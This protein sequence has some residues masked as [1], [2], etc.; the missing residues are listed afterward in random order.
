MKKIYSMFILFAFV[1]FGA[2]TAQAEDLTLTVADG[3]S[4]K[5]QLPMHGYYG[6]QAQHNQFIFLSS[7]LSSMSGATITALKFYMDKNYT[8]KNNDAPTATFRFKEVTETTVASQITVDETFQQVFS[9]TI[10]FANNEWNITLDEPYSYNGG[11]LLIDVQTTAAQYINNN[12]NKGS[13]FYSANVTYGRGNYRGTALEYIPK[14]TFTYEEAAAAGGCNKP[15]SLAIS[16]ELPDGA[17]F[18]WA[19]NADET[20]YQWACVTSGAS[21]EAWSTLAENIRTKTVEGLTAGSAY[22]FY[23]RS[24]C[25]EG[26]DE[27]SDAVK[28]TFTPS[29]PAPTFGENPVT[30][31]TAATATI[32]WNAADGISKYQYICVEK[33]AT[34]NWEE[35]KE[36]TTTSASVIGLTAYTEYDFYVR[37]WYSAN[38][39]SSAVKTTF[40]TECAAVNAPITWDFKD[41][42]AN[43]VPGCWDNSGSTSTNSA[44]EYYY[45]WGVHE[46]SGNKMLRMCNYYVKP[47]GGSI[48]LMNTPS[49]VMPA[50]PE[51][52]LSFEYTHNSNAG[53][54]TVKISKDAGANWTDLATYAKGSGSS[55]SDPGTMTPVSISLADYA[56]ETIIL[57]FY[58]PANYGSGA[59]FVDNISIKERPA[60]AKPTGLGFSEKAA[61]SV[62]LAW[63]SDASAWKVEYSENSDFSSSTIKSATENPYILSE[64]DANTHYYVRVKTDC[65]ESGESEPTDAIDFTTDCDPKI[66]PFPEDFESGTFNEC[67]SVDSRWEINTNAH[68]G[69]YCARFNSADAADLVLPSITIDD[70]AM[71]YYWHASSYPTGAVLV[72]GTQVQTIAT[73]TNG[74]WKKDSVDLTS[75]K[76]QTITITIR[77][78]YYYSGRYLYVDDIL[79]DYKPV[80]K[81]TELTVTPGNATATISWESTEGTSWNLRYRVVGAE[82]WIDSTGLTAKTKELTKL[83]NGSNYEVQVQ[84]VCSEHR[85]SDWTA[86]ANFMPQA[87]P[88]VTGVTFGAKTYNSVVVNWTTS[89]AGTWVVAYKQTSGESWTN[90]PE[91]AETSKTLSSLETGVEYTVAV[92]PSCNASGAIEETF[93]LVYSTP[94]NAAV[95]GITDNGASA[96]WDAVSDA[97]NGYKYIVVAKDVEPTWASATATNELS[98]A[99]AGLDAAVDYDFYVAAVY[100]ENLGDAAKVSFK[101]ITIAPKNFTQV[102]LSATSATYSW[103]KDGAN[104]TFEY[105]LDGENWNS[106]AT[107]QVTLNDLTANTA[108][109]LYVRSVYD[110]ELRSANASVS[111]RTECEP[112][113]ALP[114]EEGFE[115]YEV[116][117]ATSAAPACWEFINVNN[118]SYPYAYVAKNATYTKSGSQTLYIVASGSTDGY[119]ILPEFS[120]ALN[121]LQISF[122]HKEES[123]TSSAIITLGYLTDIAD[124]ET[125]H[126]IKEC[127]RATSWTNEKEI[128]LASVPADVRLAFKLG[129]AKDNWYTGIDDIKLEVLPTCIK[130]VLAAPVIL[131]DGATFTW[132]AGNGETQFQYR[133][134]EDEWTLLDENKFSVTLHGYAPSVAHTFYVRAY[135]SESD[136]SE[137]VSTSFTAFCPAPTAPE[138][139][140]ITTTT[141]TLSW[142]AAAGIDDYQYQLNGG[143]WIKVAG[144]TSVALE[145]LTASTAYS[146][147]VRSFFNET[148]QSGNASVN[149]NTACGAVALPFEEAFGGTIPCWTLENC[150]ESTGINEGKFRF[151]Y[152]SNP[153]QYLITPEITASEKEVKVEFEYNAY[154]G[155][156]E[157]SFKVGYSTTTNDLEA[158]TWGDEIKTKITTAQQYSEI[159]PA[160]VKFVAIQYTAN[161]KYYFFVDNFSITEYEAPACAVPTDLAV[162]EIGVDTAVVTWTSEASEF[163]MQVSFD[164]KSSWVDVNDPNGISSPYV[165]DGLDEHITCYVRVKAVCGEENESAW[166]EPVEFTTECEAVNMLDEDFSTGVPECWKTSGTWSTD[167]DTYGSAAPSLKYNATGA[168]EITTVAVNVT[169]EEAVLQFNI[170]NDY[171]NYGTYYRAGRV[172]VKAAEVEDFST[173][174]INSKDIANV[175]VIDLAAYYGKKITITFQVD[176]ASK[177]NVFFDDVQVRVKPCDTP[178]NLNATASLDSVVLVWEQGGDETTYQYSVVKKG[179]EADW[180]TLEAG[181]RTVTVKNLLT[182]TLYTASVRSFCGEGREGETVLTKDF[183]PLCPLPSDIVITDITVHGA[184]VA[185]TAAAGIE[186]YQWSLVED[187]WLDE[188]I[189]AATSVDLTELDAATT[190]TIYVRSYNNAT[191]VSAAINAQFTTDCDSYSMAFAED[192]NGLSAGIPNCWDNTAGT[193]DFASYRWNYYATGREGACVRFD[194][195]NNSANNTNILKTPS[196][197]IDAEKDKPELSFNFKNPAGGAFAVM[198]YDVT[199]DDTTALELGELTGVA[200]WTQKTADLKAFKGHIVQVW[201]HGTSNSAAYGLDGYIYLDDVSV[202]EHKDTPSA[203][204]NVGAEGEKVVK[205]MENGILY[206]IRDGIKY[207]A[208]GGRISE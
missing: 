143:E 206:I 165:L 140:D 162:G 32:E 193:T 111:F 28:Q 21:V 118:G 137:A 149:F 61:H 190:Y 92:Y 22:D 196:I 107:N 2:L 79:V 195:Y 91:T 191:S 145:G 46:A 74:N 58:A 131:P 163:A 1:C 73:T 12:S 16:A 7:E 205:R 18:T 106:V 120:A 8:W 55:Y 81:P 87:C 192:F 6:D 67:G 4:L 114:W 84:A 133:V 60:C 119:V 124:A 97:P 75:Y 59:I 180:K 85:V 57:Q 10:V 93:T 88:S 99:L 123:A 65:G 126:A 98:A 139:S 176:A 154:S 204:G 175:Q 148:I 117:S 161:N 202:A 127:G 51:M 160:G 54:F 183:T 136:Q 72:N 121:T 23:V 95:A 172:I 27:Q 113:S 62:K 69:S 207:N 200:E 40:R 110:G 174:F 197:E 147:L 104:T 166:T 185:W 178:K 29:C 82:N 151:Y 184:H 129:K 78:N 189:V 15:K 70:D 43:T 188:H 182:D 36:A 186:K 142:T 14:T 33:N 3:T 173:D 164:E 47:S 45:V 171:Y 96:S 71:L 49:V 103:E 13:Y 152:N 56:G 64:L 44:S 9:G 135:C 35:A 169:K 108:Y 138:V 115:D 112:V 41:E 26:E 63:T 122:W 156:Y 157:E 150:H 203:I 30:A 90:F 105:S 158:F 19:Q 168:G 179:A 134:D 101:T 53:D 198:V 31:K 80:A 125:F 194:S 86:S 144:A 34:P 5:Q 170:K 94:T 167:N 38:S 42:T 116:G 25:G 11:N 68:A 77:G 146:V 130:P 48:A 100:G 17:T 181:V 66:L 199:A 153:P 83:T 20:V 132:T 89:G 141:A 39:I 52:E 159:F 24:Y 155:S 50:S 177:G 208:Q 76:G 128:S 37:S 109:T 187:E 201:F 102:A